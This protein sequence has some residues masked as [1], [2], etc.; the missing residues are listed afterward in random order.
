MVRV[1]LL[2]FSDYVDFSKY[3]DCIDRYRGLVSSTVTPSPQEK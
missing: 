1:F 3:I 2:I